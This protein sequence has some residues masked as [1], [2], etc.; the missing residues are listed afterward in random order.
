MPITSSPLFISKTVQ[1]LPCP[2]HHEYTFIFPV[3]PL[4]DGKILVG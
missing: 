2:W 1:H 3:T 4:F